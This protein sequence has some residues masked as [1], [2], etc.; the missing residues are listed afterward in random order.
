MGR[1]A[2]RGTVLSL[3]VVAAVSFASTAWAKAQPKLNCGT[4]EHAEQ[5]LR[6][7]AR[8]LLGEAHGNAQTPR[9]VGDLACLAARQG[10]SV[11]VGLEIP[12]EEDPRIKV[13][14]ASAGA[15]GDR[16]ALLKGAFWTD[17]FQDGRRSEAMLELLQSL[18][19]LRTN[20]ADI[21]VVPFD[22]PATDRD[23][24]MAERL[25]AAFTREPKATFI[26]LSGNL[27]ARKTSGAHKFM[28]S[29]LLE[30]GA[31]LTTLDAR[32]GAG[33]TWICDMSRP[34]ECGPIAFGEG[35]GKQ[36]TITLKRFDE[37]A[38]D[39]FFELP[40]PVFSPPA[41]VPL[42]PQQQERVYRMGRRI[43][44]LSEYKARRFLAS[45]ALFVE[46]A[47]HDHGGDDA[48]SAACCFALAGKPDRAFEWLTRSVERGF[49]D[50]DGME[51]DLDLASL[52]SDPRWT[53][54]VERV[55]HPNH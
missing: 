47:E 16:E 30:K 8:L 6:P 25:W 2:R 31:T 9:F 5:V 55:R 17:S 1:T 34:P 19:G 14:L 29:Y 15:L 42:T 48:Y 45:A 49:N 11:R 4:V 51:K 36:Q 44:A 18:R 46:L 24:A 54:L 35:A 41:A 43:E 13:F 37:G 33:S 28:A 22:G 40:T 21:Q 52:K 26:M 27:H 53:T 7:G 50:A 38:Y 32:Y 3:A 39:G 23:Q 10:G 20:G 12:V